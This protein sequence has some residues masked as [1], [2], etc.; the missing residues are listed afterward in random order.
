ML[1]LAAHP[2]R[3]FCVTKSGQQPGKAPGKQRTED[4]ASAR[5]L[6]S[7]EPELSDRRFEAL[8]FLLPYMTPNRLQPLTVLRES[9]GQGFSS[10]RRFGSGARGRPA[11][12]P[13][14]ARQGRGHG[15]GSAKPQST[16]WGRGFALAP[17][18]SPPPRPGKG[19]LHSPP[20][21]PDSPT[22]AGARGTWD[23]S[24]SPGR[25]AGRGPRP[26]P[27]GGG[28]PACWSRGHR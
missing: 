22:A 5:P 28:S 19:P 2:P 24:P 14:T 13:N 16:Q 1:H 12:P 3:V 20:H 21:P 17:T 9:L 6:S 10:P 8:E 18:R 7:A 27:A 23:P 4:F 15:Q 11:P 26:G 25:A